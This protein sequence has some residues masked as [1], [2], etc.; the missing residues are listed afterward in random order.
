MLPMKKILT[1]IFIVVLLGCSYQPKEKRLSQF[2]N[3]DSQIIESFYKIQNDTIEFIR[4]L[5]DKDVLI[6]KEGQIRFGEYALTY[7]EFKRTIKIAKNSENVDSLLTHY[8]N[9]GLVTKI[10]NERDVMFIQIV[11]DSTM[12]NLEA[13][14]FLNLRQEVEG[15]ID[16]ALRAKDLGEWF[17]GDM[18]AGGNML[19]FIDNWK[20][21]IE[22]VK[23]ELEKEN[24]LDHVLI[25]K[26]ITISPEDWNYEIVYP[27][28]YEGVFNQM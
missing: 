18:G 23:T 1:F 5:T 13:L 17:A 7:Q 15:Q 21:S 22:V 19:F 2:K 24:L 8:E 10:G 20:Q 12:G 16:E 11:P 28:E 3:N 6:I 9:D 25:A 14:G 26:R 27:V 4:L